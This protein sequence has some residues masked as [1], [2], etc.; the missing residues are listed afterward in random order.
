MIATLLRPELLIPIVLVFAAALF[1]GLKN[2][3]WSIYGLLC[4]LPVSG[5]A[6]LVS[7]G[8]S[9]GERAVALLAKDFVFIIPA[10]VGFL[11]YFV[12]RRR[13]FWFPGAPLVLF[14]LLA[15]IVLIQAFNPDLPNH[16]VGL[17]GIKIWLFYIPLFFLGYYLV[18][19]RRQLFTLLGAMG[20]LAIVPAVI[21]IVEAIMY[22]SG[23]SQTVWSAYGGASLA[24]TQNHT[25]FV[26]PG[27][28]TI[29]RVPS[30][31]SF[32][33]QYY[34]FL[35]AMIAV[36]Y[37]WWRGG[38]PAGRQLKFGGALVGL[39]LVAVFT[40]G[41]RGAFLFIPVLV[42]LMLGLSWKSA[43]R[44]P[45]LAVG[46]G[47]CAFGALAVVMGTAVC[48]VTSHVTKTIGIEGP[49]L[50]PHGI[51]SA[52]HKTWL[53]LGAGADSTG[54]RYAFPNVTLKTNFGTLQEPWYIKTYLEL[55]VFGLIIVLALLL[56]ILVRGIQVHRRLRDPRLKVVSAAL[57][58]LIVLVLLYNAKAQYLDFDPMNVYFWLFAGIL[59]RLPLLQDEGD[60][61]PRPAPAET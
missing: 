9:R 15:L 39:L 10:Y 48:G 36:A 61:Q 59:M 57:V 16:L 8:T 56:T 34:L 12:K 51:Q 46:G 17:I 50:G 38:R 35:A 52:V 31:F 21:G 7:Y 60:A 45:V 4:Y 30:T 11:W 54:A 32:F 19:S 28:C 3:R 42:L 33:Y 53:G 25:T 2:W 41:L 20:A 13:K 43:N 5:I 44:I 26:L 24:A 29:S 55:G 22:W 37:A 40:S 49:Q 14:G 18:Q 27:G 47:L 1:V 23:Y 58:A 6:I